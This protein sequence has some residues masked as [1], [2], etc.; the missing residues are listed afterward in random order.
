MLFMSQLIEL[1]EVY[2]WD[3]PVYNFILITLRN[4]VIFCTYIQRYAII[5]VSIVIYVHVERVH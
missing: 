4:S 5:Y 2:S 3:A 1:N